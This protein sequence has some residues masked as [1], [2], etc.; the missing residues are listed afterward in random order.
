MRSRFARHNRSAEESLHA[1]ILS[2]P[3]GANSGASILIALFFFLICAVVGAAVLTAATVTTGQLKDLES[4]QQ[5]YYSVSSTAALFRDEIVGGTYTAASGSTAASCALNQSNAD[6]QKLLANAV[7]ETKTYGSAACDLSV[8]TGLAGTI[9][10]TA[11]FVM[12]SDY[13]I[14]ITCWPTSYSGTVGSYKVVCTIPASILYA[15][16]KTSVQS[17]TWKDA[18]ITKADSTSYSTGA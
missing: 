2:H 10:V 12:N 11:H 17:I 18:V 8:S 7:A 15:T 4:S 13:S 5:A 3:I 9:D 14:V 6:L 1:R 16:D